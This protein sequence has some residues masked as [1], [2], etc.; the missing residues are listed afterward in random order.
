MEF[1]EC[2]LNVTTTV[3]NG[4]KSIQV[5]SFLLELYKLDDQGFNMIKVKDLIKFLSSSREM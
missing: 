1:Q 5:D 2:V 3:V 4:Y